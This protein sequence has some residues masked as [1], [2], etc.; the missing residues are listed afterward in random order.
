MRRSECQD[1]SPPAYLK[2]YVTAEEQRARL[3][4]DSPFKSNVYFVRRTCI[5]S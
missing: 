4:F 3:L 2:K 5:E 1:L